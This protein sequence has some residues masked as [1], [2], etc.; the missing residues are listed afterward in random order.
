MDR[1]AWGWVEVYVEPH[2]EIPDGASMRFKA[3]AA[4]RPITFIHYESDDGDEGVWKIVAPTAEGIPKAAMACPTDDSGAGE[5]T[6][7]YGGDMGLRLTMGDLEVAEPYLIV[8]PGA[9]ADADV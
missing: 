3:N 9:I 2:D 7:I 4:P 5:S 1:P 6:L 8:A